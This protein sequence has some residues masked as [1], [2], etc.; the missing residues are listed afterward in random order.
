MPCDD[1]LNCSAYRDHLCLQVCL[2]YFG[3]SMTQPAP[4]QSVLY[5][6]SGRV[7][8]ASRLSYQVR[9]TMFDRFMQV[10]QPT[11]AHRVLDIGVTND[12][13]FPES[14]YFEKWYPHK[15]QITCVGTENGQH[16]ET[17]YP[18]I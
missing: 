13:T 3:V 15:A 17:L 7:P 11:A 6:H 14:N 8:M 10:I 16:L 2:A 1:I 9:Q 12:T 18:G 4:D 5:Q